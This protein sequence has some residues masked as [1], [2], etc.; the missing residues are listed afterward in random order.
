MCNCASKRND[1]AVTPSFKLNNQNF[2][3]QKSSMWPDAYFEYIGKTGLT[4]TGNISGKQYRFIKSGDK[5]M[6]DYRDASGFMK[7]PVLKRVLK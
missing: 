7:V 6:V 5:Q 4:V 2:E 1:V 3:P